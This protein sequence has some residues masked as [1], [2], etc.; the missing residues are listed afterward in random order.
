MITLRTR[1][2]AL[3]ERKKE[4]LLVSIIVGAPIYSIYNMPYTAILSRI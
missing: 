3:E 4:T 1:A 2:S